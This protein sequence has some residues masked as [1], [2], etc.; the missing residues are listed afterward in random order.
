MP[1]YQVSERT[2][3]KEAD[4]NGRFGAKKKHKAMFFDEIEDHMQKF[5]HF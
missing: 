1:K 2:A 5:R 4:K 3:K